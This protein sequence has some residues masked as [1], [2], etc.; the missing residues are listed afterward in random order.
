VTKVL[1]RKTRKG[2]TIH[3]IQSHLPH[4]SVALLSPCTEKNRVTGRRTVLSC[5]FMHAL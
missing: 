5:V 2:P 3:Y 4:S 1:R